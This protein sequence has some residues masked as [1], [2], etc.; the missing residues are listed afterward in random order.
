ME[1]K[2]C[3]VCNGHIVLYKKYDHHIDNNNIIFLLK[4]FIKSTLKRILRRSHIFHGNVIICESCGY[5]IMEN[6]PSFEKIQSYYKSS[7]WDWRAL[8]PIKISKEE[9]KND[10]RANTQLKL[11]SE[12]VSIAN[13]QN[14][15]EIGAGPAYA[16]LLLRDINNSLKLYICEPGE[17]WISYY[18]QLNLI[19]IADYF[20]FESVIKFDYI[21]TSHWLEH[22]SDI[23]QTLLALNKLLKINGYIFVEVPNTSIEY[24]NTNIQDTPHIHFF[25]KKSLA[26][27][28]ENFGFSCLFAEE[29]GITYHEYSNGIPMTDKYDLQEK[30]IWIRSLFIKRNELV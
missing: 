18:Q 23:N 22:V 9:Y 15:L 6:I 27:L 1:K 24:W 16:S 30:G 14:S 12:Y 10:F 3:P 26:K 4:Q 13:I 21:H 19:K 5:G 29:Y 20:P 2:V 8:K 11:I 7:Y 17:Q 28:F 25:T